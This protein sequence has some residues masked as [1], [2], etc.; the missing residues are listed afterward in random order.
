MVGLER[1][2]A[3]ELAPER[4][5]IDDLAVEDDRVAAV[6]AEHRLM[7]AFDVDDAEA[8]HAE[9]EVAVDQ[10]AGVIRTPVLETIADCRDSVLG[11]QPAAASIPACDSAHAVAVC[12]ISRRWPKRDVMPQ[13]SPARVWALLGPHRGD[14]NQILALANALGLPFE[15]KILS[16]N[17]LRRLPTGLLGATFASLDAQCR[18]L[19]EGEPPDLTISPGRRSVPVV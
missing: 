13:H 4:R 1:V 8:A 10:V 5:M 6:G 18:K 3:F 9:A 19:I 7:P 14:N 17:Q 2:P 11:H 16:Y 15:E 12:T